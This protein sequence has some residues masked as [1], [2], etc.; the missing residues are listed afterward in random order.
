MYKEWPDFLSIKR[1]YRR[2]KTDENFEIIRFKP[3]VDQRDWP[4]G[5]RH[6]YSDLKKGQF[7]KKE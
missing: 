7:R 5:T 6:P 4:G 3:L 1:V 2:E